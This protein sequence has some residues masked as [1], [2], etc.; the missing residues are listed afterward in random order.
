MA[1][2]HGNKYSDSVWKTPCFIR[3]DTLPPNCDAY[4]VGTALEDVVGRFSVDTIQLIR[5]VY[6]IY[7]YGDDAKAKAC[8]QGIEIGNIHI[9]VYASN[10][11]LPGAQMKDSNGISIPLV[12]LLIK[13]LFKSVSNANLERML[14][15]KFGIKIQGEIRYCYIRNPK[16]ELTH[17]KT[18]DRFCF[19]SKDQ[20]KVPLPKEALCG[21][22]KVR[23]FHDGQFLDKRVC[24]KCFSPDHLGYTCTKK[25]CCKI[26]KEPG[27]EPG[28]PKCGL[29]EVQN[30][31]QA[32]GGEDDEFS[33]HFPCKFTIWNI[34][35]NSSEQ[36]YIY[37]KSMANGD[38][39]SRCPIA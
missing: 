13:D 7:L 4:T 21:R 5:N 23:L 2:L 32:F 3:K 22:F 20:L 1:N 27:H 16:K 19:I 26:C 29:Y 37:K 10:P 36:A 18:G 12:R 39:K 9:D 38:T 15:E 35:V 25:Q 28:D 17:M 33:N 34:D 8:E 6:R 24:F 14:L 30:G 11:F 31:I